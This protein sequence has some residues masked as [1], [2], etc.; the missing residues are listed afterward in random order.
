MI[1]IPKLR[2][3]NYSLDDVS[4]YHYEKRFFGQKKVY[5]GDS[6]YGILTS[7]GTPRST[8]SFDFYRFDEVPLPWQFKVSSTSDGSNISINI[9][10]SWIPK[11]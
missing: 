10:S 11:K 5:S 6:Y 2:G 7:K 4:T 1:T 8:I 9:Y 3:T